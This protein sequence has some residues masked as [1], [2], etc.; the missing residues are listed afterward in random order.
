MTAHEDRKIAL[1]EL[2]MGLEEGPAPRVLSAHEIRHYA[3]NLS[4]FAEES[5]Y[6]QIVAH[7]YRGDFDAQD[8]QPVYAATNYRRDEVHADALAHAL[9]GHAATCTARTDSRGV[10]H[11]FDSPACPVHTSGL[12]TLF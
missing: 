6:R 7:V 10:T 8:A 9:I 5:A 3:E 12:L 4:R 11:H 2:T 1:A